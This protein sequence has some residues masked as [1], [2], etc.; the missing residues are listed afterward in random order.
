MSKQETKKKILPTDLL[1]VVPRHIMDKTPII[2]LS[3]DP[4]WVGLKI[5]QILGNEASDAFA[6]YRLYTEYEEF[7]DKEL[8]REKEAIFKSIAGFT[9]T[10]VLE[11]M[12]KKE[13]E[14]GINTR[15]LHPNLLSNRSS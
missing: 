11:A 15:H 7:L 2:W 12:Y 10:D 5:E 13:E 3:A 6:Y 8:A 9:P 14:F 1:D 4:V